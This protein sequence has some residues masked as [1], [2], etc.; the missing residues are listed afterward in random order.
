MN[1]RK[2]L[3]LLVIIVIPF[4]L[5]ATVQAQTVYQIDFEGG[6]ASDFWEQQLS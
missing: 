1:I 2:R 5:V 4:S 3:F 6:S